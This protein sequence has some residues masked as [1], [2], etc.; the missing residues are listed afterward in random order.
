MILIAH[1]DGRRRFSGEMFIIYFRVS[2]GGRRGRV[3]G[4]SH[5]PGDYFQINASL[6]RLQ[7]FGLAIGRNYFRHSRRLVADIVC[8]LCEFYWP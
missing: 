2:R 3:A 6:L 1:V 5:Q 8:A 4:S 7:R